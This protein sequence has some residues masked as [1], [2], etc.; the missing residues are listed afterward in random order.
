MIFCGKHEGDP[1]ELNILQA[2]SLKRKVGSFG[3]ASE[4][5]R[6]DNR[7]AKDTRNEKHTLHF[8]IHK[9]GYFALMPNPCSAGP[10]LGRPQPSFHVRAA[11]PDS[12]GRSTADPG[13]VLEGRLLPPTAGESLTVLSAQVSSIDADSFAESWHQATL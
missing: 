2:F 10:L 13:R 8:C 3:R 5:S 11:D 6:K 12:R 4:I 7:S 9:S 1:I